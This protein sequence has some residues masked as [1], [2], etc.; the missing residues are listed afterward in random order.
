MH[1]LKL[2]GGHTL[3]KIWNSLIFADWT[4]YHLARMTGVDPSETKIIDALKRSMKS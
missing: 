2:A 1:T 3:E 4:T